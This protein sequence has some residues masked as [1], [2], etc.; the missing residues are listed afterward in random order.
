[1]FSKL[2]QSWEMDTHG[3]KI[4]S[5]TMRDGSPERRIFC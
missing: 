2:E 3:L 1:M 5:R 4:D